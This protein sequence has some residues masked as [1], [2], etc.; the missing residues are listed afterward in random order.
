MF[1]RVVF[2]DFGLPKGWEQENHSLLFRTFGE[3]GGPWEEGAKVAAFDFDDTL[4]RRHS[5]S[6]AFPGVLSRLRQLHQVDRYKLVIFTNET[7]DHLKGKAKHTTLKRKLARVDAFAD[8]LQL[9]VHVFIATKHDAYRK[10]SSKDSITHPASGGTAMWDRMVHHMAASP[11]HVHK[12]S[13]FY[14]GDSSGA[15]GEFSDSDL[16]FARAV[17]IQFIH[18]DSFFRSSVPSTVAAV[19]EDEPSESAGAAKKKLKLTRFDD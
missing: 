15:P 8:K 18:C 10:P 9:P 17:G 4:V 5:D 19:R 2:G 11:E 14:V 6:L 1:G 7:L 13:S 12:V 16:L 3:D